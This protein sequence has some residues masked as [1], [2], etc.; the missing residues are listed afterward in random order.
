MNTLAAGASSPSSRDADTPQGVRPVRS[1]LIVDDDAGIRRLI[2]HSLGKVGVSS[3]ECS[4]L[5]EVGPALFEHDPDLIFLDLGLQDGDEHSVL[6][7]LAERGFPGRVQIVSG[8]STEILD[9]VCEWGRSKGLA[10]LPPFPKPFRSSA[11]K[12]LVEACS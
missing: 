9:E 10:M 7:L 5:A 8:R 12:A 6:S 3:A 1:C 2:A 11:I 4:T